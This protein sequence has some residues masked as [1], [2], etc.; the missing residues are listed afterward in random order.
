MRRNLI[1]FA[2]AV[3][4]LGACMKIEP[5]ESAEQ[6]VLPLQEQSDNSIIKS[7]IVKV[8]DDL[9]GILEN[10]TADGKM[11]T[12]SSGFNGAIDDLSI[13]SYERLYPDAGEFEPRTRTEGLHKWY[14]VRYD[15]SR[16]LVKA[17]DAFAA[18]DGIVKV[19]RPR[20]IK[21]LSLPNDPLFKWQWDLYN[22]LSINMTIIDG[23]KLY[24]SNKGASINVVDVWDGYTAGSDN[25]IVSVVDGGVDLNHPD[26]AANCIPAGPNGS[27]D[28]VNK[29]TTIVADAHGTH[30]AGTIAAVRNNG[31]GVAGIA[32]GDYAAGKPG[33]KIL[34]CQVFVGDKGADD[35]GFMRA[36]KWGADHGAVIC[37]NSWGHVYDCDENGNITPTGLQQAKSDRVEDYE[38]EGI[39][40]FIAYAGCDNKGNQLPDSRMKGGIVIFAAGNDGIAYGCPA[41][42]E[43]VIA[44]GASGP[45][46]KP[47][48]YTNY[49][50]WVDIA[51]PGGDLF[52]GGYDNGEGGENSVDSVGY[53]LGNIFNLYQSTENPNEDYQSYGYMGGTSMAC[54]HVSGVAALLVSYFG[55]P[56]FTPAELRHLLLDGAN[57]S[58]KSST[59]PIG[60]ALDAFG[61]FNL[62]VP[63][64]T[65]APDKVVD[66]SMTPLRNKISFGW[67]VP[68]DTDDAKAFGVRF[69]ISSRESSLRNSTPKNVAAGVELFDFITGSASAGDELSRTMD[70]FRY[71]TTYYVAAYAYDRS[72]NYSELSEIK[73]VTTPENHAPV[74]KNLPDGIILYGIGTGVNISMNNIF[75]DPEGDTFTVTPSMSDNSVAGIIIMGTSVRVKAN[76]VGLTELS[77]VAYDGDK[78]GTC[79][80]PVLVKANAANPVETH[81]SPVTTN[82]VISTEGE[83]ETYVRMVNATGRVVFEQTSVFSGFNPLSIDVAGL[84][85]GRYHV[86]ISYNGK[87]FNKTVVKV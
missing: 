44:V 35:A 67:K 74:V 8:D 30:V 60:P 22:D 82:L 24:S 27:Y 51:A 16:A 34:S 54:P 28:F 59:Y 31:I 39:D 4:A 81:P 36:I 21:R 69:L 72:G 49:G 71:S 13:V 46:W 33:V 26:I 79:T 12:K 23:G 65:V 62:G 10:S 66:F 15:S 20:K 17:D 68:A 9:A 7:A 3:L 73:T 11:Y 56:G 6:G 50:S 29:S 76:Q 53:S 83:A 40:Y 61:S 85:P 63:P 47:T 2:V 64:S 58:H 77:F 18:V 1:V 84:A 55:G 25:V 43:P 87:T 32:G 52:G 38:K 37:Q 14:I 5:R 42:Y 57:S 70:G 45:D 75:E 86:T 19:C 78:S 41:S 48:W 80:V